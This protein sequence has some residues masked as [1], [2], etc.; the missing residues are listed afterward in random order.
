MGNTTRESEVTKTWAWG[1]LPVS[2][3]DPAAPLLGT[4][5]CSLLP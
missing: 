4:L 2:G 1:E 3:K 5:D